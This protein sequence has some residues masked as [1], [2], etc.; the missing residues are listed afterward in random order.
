MR[1]IQWKTPNIS[2]N[3]LPMLLRMLNLKTWRNSLGRQADDMESAQDSAKEKL[4]LNGEVGTADGL[5]GG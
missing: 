2:V 4:I 5:E 3:I 1:K